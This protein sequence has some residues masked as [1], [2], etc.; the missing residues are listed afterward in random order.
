MKSVESC[1]WEHSAERKVVSFSYTRKV[2]RSNFGHQSS[3]KSSTIGNFTV[4]V[5]LIYQSTSLNV[6]SVNFSYKNFLSI[7][8]AQ[9]HSIYQH[10]D[11]LVSHE[12]QP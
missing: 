9:C 6:I 2:H 10:F 1:E 8:L 3:K 11:L 12:S 4:Y 5:N 7:A